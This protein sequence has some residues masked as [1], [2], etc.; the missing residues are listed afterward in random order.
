M[1]FTTT[2]RFGL[3]Q[4]SSGSDT[5]GRTQF[6]NAFAQIE[7]LAA[8]DAQGTRAA[9]PAPATR[10]R[11]YYATDI[12]MVY[13]DTGSAWALVGAPQSG[14]TAVRTSGQTTSGLP[15]GA[16]FYDTSEGRLYVWNGT[17]WAQVTPA[18]DWASI[19]GK[20]A[21]FPSTWATVADK[22][23]VFPTNWANV[24]DKPATMP[25]T[26]ATVSDKPTSFPAAWGDVAGKPSTYP[27]TWADVS[28]KPTEGTFDGRRFFDGDLPP[29]SGLGNDGDVYFEW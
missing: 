20:P 8:Q 17:A 22:P 4:W 5:V 18:M 19:T 28:G 29:S 14:V 13:R 26:W 3:P 7:S 2:T 24:A 25:S 10:G 12:G 6:N 16:L 21:S 15:T 11:Y 1:A 27:S 23:S 9:R